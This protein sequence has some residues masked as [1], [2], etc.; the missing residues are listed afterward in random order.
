MTSVKL[1]SILVNDEL[2]TNINTYSDIEI[3]EVIEIIT[4][5]V[6]IELTL[7]DKEPALFAVYERVL[8]DIYTDYHD[9]VVK[10]EALEQ[11]HCMN[12]QINNQ[13]ENDKLIKDIVIILNN[14]NNYVN[15]EKVE[16]Y[17][18]L[19]NSGTYKV[20]TLR[21]VQVLLQNIQEFAY[22]SD[23]LST[24]INKLVVYTNSLG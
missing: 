3:F 5:L 7:T 6:S 20:N 9:P 23:K 22:D 4:T 24:I 21:N 14:L 2:N 13:Y 11:A 10:M 16:N 12:M 17:I 18:D 8:N 19:L 15:S 1:F